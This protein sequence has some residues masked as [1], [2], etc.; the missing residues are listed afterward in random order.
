[1][2]NPHIQPT[3]KTHPDF[4]EAPLVH[5]IDTD[6][7]KLDPVQLQAYIAHIREFRGNPA[8]VKAATRTTRKDGSAKLGA[9]LS[10]LL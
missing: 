5:L 9:D 6:P 4:I 10:A 3:L 7:A 2:S 8:T 1:M